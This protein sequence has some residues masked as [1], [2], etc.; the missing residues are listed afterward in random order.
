MLARAPAAAQTLRA[1]RA[2]APAPS[3]VRP[4][5]E[6]VSRP[7]AAFDLCQRRRQHAA[8]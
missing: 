1:L 2:T 4:A 8:V 3:S 6:R 7:R 5:S